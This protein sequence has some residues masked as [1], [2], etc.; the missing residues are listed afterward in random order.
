MKRKGKLTISQKTKRVKEVK[1]LL[2]N[3]DIT[4]L[5]SST[6][7]IL[8]DNSTS[9]AFAEIGAI[10]KKGEIWYWNKSFQGLETTAGSR[11]AGCVRASGWV[12]AQR[13]QRASQSPF[14]GALD[15]RS[16]F[17][18]IT[19]RQVRKISMIRRIRRRPRSKDSAG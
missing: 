19:Y 6:K 3:Y 11:A 12:A 7:K 17:D 18:L 15:W 5:N 2:I 14:S 8:K 10:E 16:Q 13:A 4:N 1:A 9:K